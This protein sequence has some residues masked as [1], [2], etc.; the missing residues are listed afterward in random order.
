[1]AMLDLAKPATKTV[2]TFCSLCK[3][4]CP[5]V[6]T[7]EN[8]VPVSLAPDRE[9]SRGGAVCAKGRAAPEIHDHPHRVNYPIRRTRPKSDPDPGWERITWDEALDTIAA[10]LREVK[11]TSGAHAVAFSRGTGS[12]TGVRDAD[13]WLT[14]LVNHFG[15]PNMMST[16]HVC[17]WSRDGASYYTYGQANLPLP[18]TAESACIVLWGTNPSA[19]QLGLARD[20]IA[21]KARGA[22][23]VVVDPRKVG[24]A[25]KA[26]RVLQLRPGTDG[27]LALAFIDVLI[28]DDLIDEAFVRSWTNAAL[29]VRNDTGRL[30]GATDVASERLAQDDLAGTTTPYLALDRASGR[31]VAYDAATR[32]YAQPTDTLALRGITEVS[33]ADGSVVTCRTVFDLLAETARGSRPEIAAEITGVTAQEIVAAVHLIA[34]NR[35]VS[36]YLYNGLVQHTNGVQACRAIEI[37]Y[38]LLGDWDRAGGNVIPAPLTI[39]D[40]ASRGALPNEAAALRLGSVERPLGPAAAPPGNIAAFDLY[41][42]IVEGTPYKVRALV[43][44]G[45]NILLAN[46]DSVQGRAALA[47]LEFFAQ[48]E[49]FH[50]P[51]SQYA[52]I[53]LPAADFLESESLSVSTGTVAQRRP[54]VVEPLYERRPDVDLIFGLATRLGLGDRFGDGDLAAAFDDVLAPA[55]FSWDALADEPEGL[56][57]APSLSYQKY[58]NVRPDG[59]PVGFGTPSGLV[60]LFSDRFA[61]YGHAPLPSYEEPAESPHSTPELAARFPLVLTNAK[62]PQYLHSQHRAVTAIRKTMTAPQAEMHPE[63]A[64]Q[65]GVVQGAWIEIES[66]RG[67]VRA[68]A[69]LTASIVPGVVCGSHGW[70]EGCEDLGI[71]GMDP[72]DAKGANLNLLV[73]AD[74]KDPISGG[75]PHRSSLCRI[76]A[77]DASEL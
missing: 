60:E 64:A 18:H 11:E 47:Q 70:W 54:A 34:G 52:D 6:V 59:R 28:Q 12:A 75:L 45:N 40:I 30:L 23:L 25:N 39:K 76:R 9:H 20:V 14:R 62:R 29:L 43:A 73:H 4:I 38:A 22:R 66:P 35:P 3:V 68:Q 55:G 50:T 2:R 13:P 58:T 44:L 26:D 49:L 63:T 36:H 57:I 32:Q 71:G 51:T 33:L 69:E 46:A 41:T 61:A 27:A 67:K 42:S 8:G 15:S 72:F 31:L 56:P 37:F 17:N 16:T 65:Y 21:A 53:V 74:L 48:A 7:V 77:L 19:T 5:A 1:M 10:K 24:V